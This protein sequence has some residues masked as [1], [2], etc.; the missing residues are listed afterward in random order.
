MLIASTIRINLTC[1]A[2]H[3]KVQNN[4]EKNF[5]RCKYIEVYNVHGLESSILLSCHFFQN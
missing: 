1:T 4:A 3:W 2:L 5:K